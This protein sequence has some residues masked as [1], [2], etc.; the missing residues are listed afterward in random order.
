MR[1]DGRTVFRSLWCFASVHGGCD[2]RFGAE[3][4]AALRETTLVL[5][6]MLQGCVVRLSRQC[7]ALPLFS[8]PLFEFFQHWWRRPRSPSSLKYLALD[9]AHERRCILHLFFSASLCGGILTASWSFYFHTLPS[10]G[11]AFG[12]LCKA[13]GPCMVLVFFNAKTTLT[14]IA[15]ATDSGAR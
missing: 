8:D 6:S 11:A 3:A 4:L 10:R 1:E 15:T 12:R 2:G 13:I 14:A 7:E 5:V 9:T